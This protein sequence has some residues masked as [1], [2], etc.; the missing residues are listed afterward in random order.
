MSMSI[1]TTPSTTSGTQTDPP[2]PSVPFGLQPMA[3]VIASFPPYPGFPTASMRAQL[4]QWKSSVGATV[5]TELAARQEAV[6]L[7]RLECENAHA[8]GLLNAVQLRATREILGD[9]GDDSRYTSS[10]GEY[11]TDEDEEN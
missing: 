7:W 4:D 9:Y 6:R 3:L 2:L 10:S 5:F 1:S 8:Q 11:S